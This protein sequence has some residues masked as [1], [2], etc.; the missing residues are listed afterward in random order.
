MN[1]KKQQIFINDFDLFC[2][3]MRSAVKIVS[4]AKFIINQNGLSIYGARSTIAR[5]ELT[6]NSIYSNELIEFSILDLNMFVKILNSIES[7]HEHDYS[8]F[9]ITVNLPF[10]KF[11]SKKF[12]TKLTTCNEEVISKWIS[13]K[14]E[15]K[16]TPEFEFTTSSDFIK[17]IINHSF[18]FNDQSALRIYLETKDDMEKNTLFATIGNKDNNLNNELT[19]K[20]GLVTFGKIA[21]NR[22]IILDIERLTLFNTY[23]SNEIKISL[24]NMNVLVSN[25][26]STGKNDSYCQLT[27]YNT[28]L[29][30]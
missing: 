1:S 22:K 26:V 19:L 16:L 3:I 13:K 5:C 2:G 29:K 20:A 12:K 17:R 21:D 23:A 25:V 11:D 27:I 14:V 9:T 28:I 30:S 4:S 10:I 15:T 7:I 8:D 24:M 18:I 6:T